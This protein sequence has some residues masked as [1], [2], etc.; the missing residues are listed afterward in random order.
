MP[1]DMAGVIEVE[2]HPCSGRAGLV[3]HCWHLLQRST[4]LPDGPCREV[5]ECCWCRAMKTI[6]YDLVPT[7]GHGPYAPKTWRV[8]REARSGRSPV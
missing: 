3:D 2:L 8:A 1:Y 7:E 5:R 4:S 6:D